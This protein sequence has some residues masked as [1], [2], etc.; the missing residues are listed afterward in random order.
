MSW[1]SDSVRVFAAAF[2]L[3]LAIFTIWLLTATNWRTPLP[4]AMQHSPLIA[5]GEQVFKENGCFY[6]CHAV[7][8]L[9]K[10]GRQPVLRNQQGVVPPDLT[11]GT[12]RTDDW[13]LAYLIYPQLLLP[14]SPMRSYNYLGNENLKSLI[15]YLQSI[16]TTALYAS[17]QP[18]ELTDIPQV[19]LNFET[20]QKGR[21]IYETNCK[22]CHGYAGNGKG[23]TGHLL[24]PEP[25]DFTDAVW[26]SK[27]TDR[28][29]F[30]I[31]TKGKS[32]T[33]MPAYGD[34]FSPVEIA[35]VLKYIKLFSDPITR[36][37]MELPLRDNN[38]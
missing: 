4:I 36:Q 37:R 2:L 8:S 15:A 33:A 23:V 26:M 9:S 29:L 16:K 18:S 6:S 25:R 34:T 32:N 35:S 13:L 20:Y 27:Q 3:A 5:K 11:T 30:S 31:I 1:L 10:K 21:F 24:L 12:Q 17:P 38:R 28:Y 14:A 7:G 22:G 19:L